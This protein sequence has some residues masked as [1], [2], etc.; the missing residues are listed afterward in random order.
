MQCNSPVSTVMLPRLC[1]YAESC[2]NKSTNES[3]QSSP[4]SSGVPGLKLEEISLYG[5][6]LP[7]DPISNTQS[8]SSMNMDSD[9]GLLASEIEDSLTDADTTLCKTRVEFTMSTRLVLL[10]STVVTTVGSMTL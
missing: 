2:G 3:F 6:L 10:F 7:S 5:D 8:L 4:R 1:N 9:L